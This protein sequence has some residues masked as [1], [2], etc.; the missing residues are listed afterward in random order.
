MVGQARIMDSG[1]LRL[2]LQKRRDHGR[3]R[4]LSLDPRVER[5]KTAKRQPCVKRRS[6]RANDVAPRPQP[7]GIFGPGRDDHSSDH[8]GMPVQEFGGRMDHDVDRLRFLNKGQSWVVRALD[9]LLPRVRNEQLHDDLKRMRDA[10]I[11]NIA[12][13]EALIER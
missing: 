2:L 11:V 4:L 5:A 6:G 10:H 8:I 1:H 13:A 9:A 12:A 3:S 7:L